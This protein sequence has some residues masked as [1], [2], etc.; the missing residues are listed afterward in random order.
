MLITIHQPEH[1]PWLGFF[2]KM[3]NADVIILLDNCPFRKNYYQNRN[4]IRGSSGLDWITVPVVKKALTHTLIKDVKIA[5]IEWERKYYGHILQAYAGARRYDVVQGEIRNVIQTFHN[6]GRGF[7]AEL[8]HRIIAMFAAQLDITTEVVF[9]DYKCLDEWGSNR[10]LC[11][12]K[13]LSRMWKIPLDDIT[14]IAGPFGRDYIDERSFM[15]A[16]IEIIYNDFVHPEYKQVYEPFIPY[17]STIDLLM[18]YNP[19]DAMTI[20]KSGFTV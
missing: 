16:G 20:I 15:D 9:A 8:N 19:D 4:R 2:N 14:Y 6:T 17:A 5:P 11:L 7:I 10:L 13:C 1:M 3:N 12:L 18:S